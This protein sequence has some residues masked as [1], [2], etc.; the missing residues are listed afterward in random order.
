MKIPYKSKL[1]SIK[2]IKSRNKV[3]KTLTSEEKR[4]EIAY[5]ALN[6]ILTGNVT[7]IRLD[8]WSKELYD[9]RCKTPAE[10]QELL[11][12]KLPKCSVCQRGLMMLSVIRLG[13]EVS[14][15]NMFRNDGN[16][17]ILKSKG[18]DV[19]TFIDMEHQFEGW[20]DKKSPYEKRSLKKMANICCNI[21]A[22]GNFTTKDLTD[23]L[24]LWDIKIK[25]KPF[26]L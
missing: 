5:D 1:P 19:E 26:L 17:G 25:E 15:T 12:T 23:Y 6:I 3:F 18:F 2:S 11:Y 21:I 9:I 14:S 24:T 10:F 7:P 13:N 20:S 16:N 8:Y 4:K 22:N